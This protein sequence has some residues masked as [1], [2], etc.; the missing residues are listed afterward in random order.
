MT[1]SRQLILLILA[2]FLLVFS[3]TLWISI[4]NTRSYLML[5]LATQTQNAADSLGLS[6]AP[7]MQKR[8]IAAMDTMVNAVFDSGYYKSLKLVS[9]SG[10][11]LLER[12]N[13]ARIEGVPPWFIQYLTLDTPKAESLITT[14]WTQAGRLQLVAHPGFAYQKLWQTSIDMLWWSLLAFMTM[15]IGVFIL[16]KAILKPLGAVEQQALAIGEREFPIVKT[17][18]RTR[19]LKRVVLAMNKMSGKVEGLINTLSERAE[20]LRRQ[21]HHDALTGLINRRG[22]NARLDNVIRD[23]ETGGS[24]ALAVIRMKDVAAYNAQFGH[25]AGSAL[26]LEVGQL[27]TSLSE[28]YPDAT[29]ARIT[30]TDFAMIL[31][32]IGAD[33]AAEFGDSLCAGLDELA[34][35]LHVDDIAH[36]GIT[37]FDHT[38]QSGEILADADASLSLAEHRGANA[39]V[40]QGGDSEAMG[41]EAWKKLIT[42]AIEHKQI[43]LIIQ[44]VVNQQRQPIFGEALIRI[45]SEAGRDV[46]PA[47]FAS[48]A[49]RLEMHGMLDRF[50]VEQ[51]TQSLT[52]DASRKLAA[53]LSDRS[54]RDAGFIGWLAEHLEQYKDVA[55]LM[56]FE[57]TEYA[58]LQH[59][60]EA[61]DF[62]ALIHAHGGAVVLEHFGTRLSSFQILR[63]L[64]L[65]YIKLDGS[66]TRGIAEH[67]DNRFFL[68]TVTDIA[69]GL[70]IL[71]IA[72]H[73]ETEEDAQSL[74]SLG[75]DAMQ[76]YYFGQSEPLA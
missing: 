38:S 14:G 56:C 73:V 51:T 22:F 4:E 26:L 64:K 45:N 54:I 65:D 28:D 23:R 27:L 42:H 75:I 5:Q 66:Y 71:V 46:S 76:G 13:T 10:K 61:E 19:E 60:T 49:D 41:N 32:L 62:I 55:D 8:D 58:L 12:Q 74:K 15:L 67:S 50:V 30:G 44:P 59:V 37:G 6:L 24:G 1:L 57:M 3:G 31:P 63:R 25:Q 2:A 9:M 35:A 40:I 21:A 52:L 7:H 33:G 34:A 47:L 18:P 20:Q 69:H 17:I 72:E 70:D 36:V 39:C 48:M 11:V 29:A 53:K 68:Q 16:L 43:R